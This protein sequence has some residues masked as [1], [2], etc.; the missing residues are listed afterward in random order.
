MTINENITLTELANGDHNVTVY[1]TDEAGNTG[2][3]ETLYFIVDAS[4]PFPIILVAA[5]SVATAVVV[6]LVCWCTSR[7]D[8]LKQNQV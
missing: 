5:P 4:E 2:A 1:A 3:S 7:E 6:L 8:S